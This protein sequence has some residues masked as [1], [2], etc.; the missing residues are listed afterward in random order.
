MTNFTIKFII[1]PVDQ[2]VPKEQD[3]SQV[4]QDIMSKRWKKGYLKEDVEQRK[5]PKVDEAQNEIRTNCSKADS[6]NFSRSE[7]DFF[8][9]L[10]HL[11]GSSSLGG[12]ELNIIKF[13]SIDNN[14]KIVFPRKAFDRGEKNF[15]IIQFIIVVN[16]PQ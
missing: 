11:S 8:C 14:G 9:N 3:K 15:E 2:I 4:F 7:K 6:I 13:I 16:S 10:I 1:Q 12:S 5:V